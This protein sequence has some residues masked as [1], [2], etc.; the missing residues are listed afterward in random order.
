MGYVL[1][2]ISEE[3]C[4]TITLN[5]PEKMNAI[6]KQMVQELREVLE[7]VRTLETLKLVLITGAGDRA[8]CAG[9]DLKD[10]HGE[11]AA[12]EAYE[13]LV[14]M[15]E[16]LYKIATLPV[17]TIALLNGQARGGGCEIATACDFRY[18]VSDASFGFVQGD[19]GIRPG[20]GGGVLLYER[21]AAAQAAHWLMDAEMYEAAETL[22][23]GWLHKMGTLEQLQSGRFIESF[24]N[25]TE[26]Q[27]RQFKSQ[28]LSSLSIKGLSDRMDEEVKE[29]AVLWESEEHKL[30]VQKFMSS[31]KN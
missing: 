22:R 29:C 7:S 19:L 1:L 27:M 31:R 23:I 12:R 3:G 11:M 17:P 9:G 8:F 28:Y 18:G 15:K 5:R 25:K 6:N 20:W 13:L 4:A 26:T 16:V 30:A 24:L 10:F 14:P 2:D 21:I